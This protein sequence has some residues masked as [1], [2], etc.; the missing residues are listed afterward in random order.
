[1]WAHP[2]S[3]KV[4]MHMARSHVCVFP[5]SFSS[6]RHTP[7]SG[8][9]LETSVWSSNPHLLPFLYTTAVYL[10][11][12]GRQTRQRRARWRVLHSFRSSRDCYIYMPRK[13]QRASSSTGAP[14]DVNPLFQSLG[15]GMSARGKM[16]NRKEKTNVPIRLSPWSL[17]LL[18]SCVCVCVCLFCWNS[19]LLSQDRWH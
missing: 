12:S 3:L 7:P 1:M 5:F 18:L 8:G 14:Q 4:I 15:W 19:G 13:L 6:F 16:K 10:R 11:D 2:Q 9:E 17:C